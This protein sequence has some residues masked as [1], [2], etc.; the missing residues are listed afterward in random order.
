[1]YYTSMQNEITMQRRIIRIHYLGTRYIQAR[2]K[3][4]TY[5]FHVQFMKYFMCNV[6][7]DVPFGVWINDVNVH[8]RG[9]EQKTVKL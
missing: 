2:F 1:M 7:F 9:Y 4:Q 6:R 5:M 3:Q 8:G